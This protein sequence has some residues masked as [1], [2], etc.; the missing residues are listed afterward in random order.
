[1]VKEIISFRK[2]G[3]FK[4]KKLLILAIA[5]TVLMF[6]FST[7][8]A[9]WT[10]QYP[11]G[12][13]VFPYFNATSGFQTFILISQVDTDPDW[14]QN[15]E[16][17]NVVVKFNPKCGRGSSRSFS[18]TTKQSFVV[19]PPQQIEG[20]VEAFVKSDISDWYLSVGEEALTGIA[21]VLDIGNGITYNI[22]STQ[23][24]R[25]ICTD[26]A[27]EP[28]FYN[29]DCTADCDDPDW[30]DTADTSP[31]FAR[32]WRNSANGRSMFVLCDP[33][34]RH[35]ATDN[36]P[37]ASP[38]AGWQPSA[39]YVSNEAQLDIY[40]K[41][42]SDAHL[43]VDWCTG[44]DAGK[45]GIVT[46]GVGTT[47]GP[48]GTTDTTIA[49]PAATST[50]A[51]YG[52]GQAYQMRNYF[53]VDINGDG[54]MSSAAQAYTEESISDYSNILGAVLTRISPTYFPHA[55]Q[56]QSMANKYTKARFCQ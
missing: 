32:L 20:W 2:E 55:T 9:F 45:P 34:G 25:E 35:V 7:A 28:L 10:W 36:I 41:S 30:G 21:V 51:P 43:T 50:D 54:L 47:A 49:D 38:A 26:S 22:E 15:D 6:S 27:N 1:L 48:L 29:C 19:T 16:S 39:L 17:P 4:V 11:S 44:D 53:W 24:R 12:A 46:I 40:S 5:A 8:S 18:L 56:A 3:G 42:E 14:G 33:S 31:L 37:D 23:Y 13:M 52:F